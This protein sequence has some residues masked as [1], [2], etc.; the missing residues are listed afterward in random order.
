MPDNWQSIPAAFQYCYATIPGVSN[1]SD[2]TWEFGH[3]Y[4]IGIAAIP[5]SG[6]FCVSGLKITSSNIYHEGIQQTVYGLTPDIEYHLTF[7]QAVV[8]QEDVLDSSGHW[9]VYLDDQLL[10]ETESSYSDLAYNNVN[11]NWE[12]RSFSFVALLDSHNFKFLPSGEEFPHFVRMG[13]DL[14]NLTC[15]P[16][17]ELRNDTTICDGHSVMIDA[18][19]HN[20]SY[21]WMD[22]DTNAIRNVSAAG[23][24]I[25]EVSN[26]CHTVKDSV[27]IKLKDCPVFLEM[28]NIFTP[29]GDGVNDVFSPVIISEI[30]SWHL[31][32]VDRWG[33][34]VFESSD[35]ENYW[36]GINVKGEMSSDGVYFWVMT[37]TDS[38]D[39]EYN[40]SGKIYLL[41]GQ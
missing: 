18:S 8:K 41:S 9:K 31:I 14:I 20:A 15:E 16:K 36:D 30:S 23:N 27:E 29:N 40:Q 6:T 5:Y 39:E 21:L 4:S 25:V 10:G 17:Y 38:F 33:K 19:S 26:P 7:Y 24:Y 32:I 11:V 13:I 37:A 28:P 12:K 22:G 34:V 35:P 1:T 2:L 3:N